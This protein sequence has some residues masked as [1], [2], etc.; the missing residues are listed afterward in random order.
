MDFCT[1]R[2]CLCLNIHI[3]ATIIKGKITL[4]YISQRICKRESG[5]VS[6]YGFLYFC[7]T[8]SCLFLIC[9]PISECNRFLA[10]FFNFDL[11][12]A[13]LTAPGSQIVLRVK[14]ICPFQHRCWG[15]RRN[16]RWGRCGRSCRCRCYSGNSFQCRDC[17]C[18]S[19]STFFLCWS[20]RVPDN[21]SRI[22]RIITIIRSFISLFFFLFRFCFPLFVTDKSASPLLF[23][24]RYYPTV[25]L[26]ILF[27]PS[28]RYRVYMVKFQWKLSDHQVCG[29][30]VM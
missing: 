8:G 1:L 23:L 28:N 2:F 6:C 10:E 17:F 30:S 25:R 4:C 22:N 9:L 13:I 27:H 24:V 3:K 18:F 26:L 12:P 7:L 16:R 20:S 11:N 15:Y 5:R 14:N 29:I 21:I 19:L